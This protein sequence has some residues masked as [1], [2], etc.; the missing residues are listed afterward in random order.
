MR[1]WVD[2]LT[3]K[4]VLFF[5]PLI[6]L[7]RGRGAEVLVTSRHY[8]EVEQLARLQGLSLN[9]V[10]ERGGKGPSSQLQ[11][12]ISRMQRLLP[13]VENFQPD[14][15]ISV[16]SA[17]CARISFGIRVRHVAVNDSPHSTVAARLSVPLS[18]HLFTPWIIPFDSWTAYGISKTKITRYKALDPAAWLKRERRAAPLPLELDRS[19][20]T[21]VVRTEESYAPYMF[22]K[23]ESWTDKVLSGLRRDFR[24]VNVI[25][26]NRYEEQLHHIRERFGRAFII[27]DNVVDGA[28][29]IRASD[30]FIGMG[31]TMTTEA[32]LLGV[33]T[34]SVFQGDELLTEKFLVSKQLLTKTRNLG[35]LSKLVKKH[36]EGKGREALK[37]RAKKLLDSME[38]PAQRIARYLL[39]LGNAE[40]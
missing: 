1:L 20:K 33:P 23:D 26:L 38:D 36:L 19:R 24:E 31:G 5:H 40:N 10:G 11:A 16:A 28:A 25:V 14:V 3:P 12:S 30:V 4:Q 17:D 39:Q 6:E 18:H 2:L 13:L 15:S 8:R 7:L 21:V 22:G 32:S 35:T 29:L 34:I 37:I 9:L 27:P